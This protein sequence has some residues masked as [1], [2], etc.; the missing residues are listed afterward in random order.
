MSIKSILVGGVMT[1]T[2][3]PLATAARADAVEDFYK[4][5]TIYALVGVSPGGGYDLELR[6]VARHIGKHIP[7]HPTVVAQNMTGATGMVM[8]NYLYRVAPKDGTY[9]GLIQNGLPT[10]QA[11]GLEGV[12][13][14]ASK[15][16]WIGSVAPTV[17]TMA[18]WK[19]TGVKTIEDAT[20]KEVITGCV[21][22]SGITLT[23]PVMLNDLLGT[24]FKM[25]MGYTGSGPLNI[26]MERGEVSARNNSWSS[27]KASKPEWVA[28]KDINVLVYSG[29]KPSD[30][31]GVPSL[32]SLVKSEEDLQ[33]VKIVTAGNGLG[34]PFA[35]P[36]GVPAERLAAIRKAFQ[37]MLKDPDFIKEAEKLKVDIDPVS[38]EDLEAAALGALH[39]S[40]KA[41]KRA[42]AYFQ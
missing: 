27:W 1:V 11:V 38:A 14:D 28:N 12:Q 15:Y 32:T 41:K 5:K 21:G 13:F 40:D 33:V 19:T 18:V 9:I 39:A 34:H 16:N 30:L 10:S 31:N 22:S 3:L 37:D 2:L 8:A 29:P 42:R 6:L 23:Y 35:M 17:E 24:K 36:P 26:A 7:G 25:V 20:K 4:G